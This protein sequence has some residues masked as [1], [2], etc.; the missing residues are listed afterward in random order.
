MF[1]QIL[2]FVVGSIIFLGCTLEGNEITAADSTVLKRVSEVLVVAKG[3]ANYKTNPAS[4]RELAFL[5][6]FD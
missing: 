4:L 5:P 2:F 3:L 1:K 6:A